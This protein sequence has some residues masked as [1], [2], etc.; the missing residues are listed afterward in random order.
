MHRN[1]IYSDWKRTGDLARCKWD[2]LTD[3]ELASINGDR[4]LLVSRLRTIY[5]M[6]AD[7]A[8]FEID[9][10]ERHHLTRQSVL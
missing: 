10:F 8:E 6:S 2:Q 4:T 7:Q 1:G 3:Y 9:Q 5:H